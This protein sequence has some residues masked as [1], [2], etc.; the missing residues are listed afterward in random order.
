L[1]AH[2]ADSAARGEIPVKNL[3][4]CPERSTRW[5]AVVVLAFACFALSSA[6]L[7]YAQDGPGI[8]G[9]FSANPDQFFIGGHY[10]SKPIWDQLRFQP[11]VE[12]GFGDDRTLVG[13]NIEFAYWMSVNPDWH[14]YVG[15]GPAMNL[16]SGNGSG[17]GDGDD[18]G[19]GLNILAGFRRRGGLFFE[20][21]VGA[22]DSPDFKLAVGYTF[23]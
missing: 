9:G 11:N 4:D 19:P 6:G 20:V 8:R 1:A 10:V 13:F 18:L 3:L 5:A 15:G 7:A 12:A 16:F 14:V 22:F 23:R 17:H 21:K 2:G